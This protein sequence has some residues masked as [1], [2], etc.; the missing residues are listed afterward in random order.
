M[1]FVTKL[2]NSLKRIIRYRQGS[3]SNIDYWEKRVSTYGG[4]AVYNILHS[5]DE[6]KDVTLFQKQIIFPEL[7]KYL[8][9]SENTVLDFGCGTGRFT[10]DLGALINGKAI[11]VDPIESLLKIAPLTNSIQYIKIVPGKKIPL[12]DNT[13]DV[14]FICLVLGG[15]KEKEL[16]YLVKDFKRML[17]NNAL[18]CLIENTSSQPNGAYW[19]F[20]DDEWYQKLFYF[21]ALKKV[22]NYEDLGENISV[23]IGRAL[24]NYI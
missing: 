18:I 10:S 24:G 14:L 12:K 19:Y 8:T 20:R 16:N 4:K 23:F 11:G 3:G 1:K 6:L 13:I 5:E 21:A 9:G 2:K 7:K 15:I 22:C 17:S